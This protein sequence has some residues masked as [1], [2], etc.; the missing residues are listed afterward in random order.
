VINLAAEKTYN[1]L[2]ITLK[3]AN[4]HRNEWFEGV[5]KC[6]LE[7]TLFVIMERIVKAE[8][9]RLVVV[10]EQ[11]RVVGVLSLSDILQYLVMRPEVKDIMAPDLKELMARSESP[12][13][14]VITPTT[15]QPF[16]PSMPSEDD[17]SAQPEEETNE[18]NNNSLSPSDLNGSR[19]NPT[20]IEEE[21]E[22]P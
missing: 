18:A 4:E 13:P 9:H 3:Q 21:D 11:D 15:P 8:V 12:R 14:E 16:D 5:H 6:T 10:D 19:D 17:S 22:K 2:D 7:E 20:I 1:N